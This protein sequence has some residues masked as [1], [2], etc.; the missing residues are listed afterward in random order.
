VVPSV[1]PQIRA[2]I[3]AS[4]A[5]TPTWKHL[6]PDR[7]SPSAILVLLLLSPTRPLSPSLYDRSLITLLV[8]CC[9]LLHLWT[10]CI[11]ASAHVLFAV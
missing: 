8:H 7:N 1:S 3:I 5:G 6:E 2:P 4:R 9:L 11:F 10:C